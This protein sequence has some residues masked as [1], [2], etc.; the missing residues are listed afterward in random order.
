ME[1]R[2]SSSALFTELVRLLVTLATT[3]G[4]YFA[5]RSWFG[6]TN[7][8]VATTTGAVLGAGI[9]YVGGG[10]FG[11]LLDRLLRSAP[12]RLRGASGPEL[13]A[14]AVGAALGV[15]FGVVAGVPAVFFLPPVA[16]WP[17]AG[18]VV[19]VLASFGGR[20]FAARSH[21][22][23][24][25]I[26]L[27]ARDPAWSPLPGASGGYVVD[28]SA[29]IDGRVLDLARAGFLVGIVMV[30]EFILDELQAIADSGDR[31]RRRRGRRGLDVLDALRD[32]AGCDVIVDRRSMPGYE[33]V[34]AKVAALAAAE[35][36][37]LVTTDHNLAKAAGV[38]GIRILNPHALGESLAPIWATGDKLRVA[39]ERTGTEPGQGVGFL[40]DGTM[41]VVEGGAELVGESVDVEI[42]NYLRTSVGRMV[43]AKM[44]Q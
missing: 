16:G 40:D 27:R 22:L 25:A 18:L 37:T 6:D 20:V 11:R 2:S 36:A 14:G 32:V 5:G 21:D 35:G 41:V 44:Q 42:S 19:L 34:D 43:F 38:R 39:V 17:L 9:G 3:A 12:D 33:D 1:R 30:P 28:S 24:A 13:I 7:P 26:G 23:L 10:I 15:F 4:G 31:S 8:D 29:A